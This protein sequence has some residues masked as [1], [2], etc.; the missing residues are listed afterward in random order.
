MFLFRGFNSGR[1][2]FWSRQKQL[3]INNMARSRFCLASPISSVGYRIDVRAAAGKHDSNSARYFTFHSRN[4]MQRDLVVADGGSP[5]LTKRYSTPLFTPIFAASP[6]KDA[7]GVSSVA[8]I[9]A[10]SCSSENEIFVSSV[11]SVSGRFIGVSGDF[12][13]ETLPCCSRRAAKS[14]TSPPTLA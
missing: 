9:F 1:L 5:F 3:F 4:A 10:R 2:L 8:T 6:D 14:I 12:I 13:N 11:S 7:F